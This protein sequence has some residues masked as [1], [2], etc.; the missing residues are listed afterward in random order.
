MST[1]RLKHTTIKPSTRRSPE[2]T[3][4]RRGT[5]LIA[6]GHTTVD[7]SQGAIAALMPFLVLQG[8]Y[9]YSAAAGVMLTFSL[10]SSII[11]PVLGIMGDKWR[12]RWIIPVSVFLSGAGIA[13]IGLVDSYWA[14][15][16]LASAAGI[17]VAAFHPASASRAR[18][19]SGGDHVLMSW[20]SLGG[21][22]GFALGPVIVAITIGVFGLS[23][24]PL[25]MIPALT[26]TIAVL[27]LN[28]YGAAQ[29]ATKAGVDTHRRDDWV[30]FGRM[31]IAILCRSIVFVGIGTFIVLFMHEYRGVQEDLA[32]ASLF[33][34]YIMGAFGTAIGGHLARR[35]NRTT[36]L[37][38]SYLLS[39]PLLAGM[40]LI[41]GSI[42]WV[43]IVLVALT[44]Y[45]PFSLQVTLG[46]DYL[47]Q[48]M[49][50]ASGVTLGLAVSIGGVATPLIGALADRVGLE[51]A[52]LP[53]IAL[54]AVA[55][56]ALWELQDPSTRVV[57][58]RD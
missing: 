55:F 57:E 46:Q 54:P 38:W 6:F 27:V 30:S 13:A 5:L 3:T 58:V 19:V 11:Q 14:V 12:M 31:S 44:L 10:V 26:G 36:L 56:I 23:A 2:E 39:I 20:Y 29:P 21:N 17:G 25:L 15:A 4:A 32:N 48:H 53:L 33:I 41:P 42:A 51:Y 1:A 16:L 8:G 50:T 18:E 52:L 49:S 43:F 45:V 24:T 47:P 28:K 22:F 7:F 34:F 9:S 35:W 40:F 37:R